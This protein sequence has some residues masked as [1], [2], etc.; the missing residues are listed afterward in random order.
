MEPTKPTTDVSHFTAL[1]IRV[2]TI[3]A[4]HPFPE[5]RKPAW[6]LTLDMGPTIGQLQSS[7][8]LTALYDKQALLGR[9]VLVVVNF[10][11]KQIGPFVSEC[12]VLGVYAADQS[13][14]LIQPDRPV[15][16]GSVLG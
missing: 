1:D 5:A 7:A 16:N 6:Q 14:V 4:V 12:L 2:G 3:I 8:Q 13:V 9:Q 10:P 15:P 11:P